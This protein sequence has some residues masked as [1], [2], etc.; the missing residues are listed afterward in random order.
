[1]QH[2]GVVLGIHGVAGHVHRFL[3]RGNVGYCGR[4]ALIQSFSA[5]TGA[6]LV[7]RK[8]LYEAV[9]GLNEVELQVACNDI[10]FCLNLREAGYRNIFTPYAE[11]YHHESASRGFDDTPEKQARSAKEVAYMHERWG[12]AL[13]ND[14][15]YN[16]NLTLDFEDFSLAWPP[17]LAG[18]AQGER[19]T[20]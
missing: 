6:C 4:A 7:V 9:G 3:P 14:P 20:S 13:R 12:D 8:A 2:A 19:P 10:D 11:L 18:I 16:P 15:A 1:L 5:V 17:R